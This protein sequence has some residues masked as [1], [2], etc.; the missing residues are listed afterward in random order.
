MSLG[1]LSQLTFDG[2]YGNSLFFKDLEGFF[3]I[4]CEVA[5]SLGQ[6]TGEQS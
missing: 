4:T 2:F 3:G 5:G 1:I 6:E